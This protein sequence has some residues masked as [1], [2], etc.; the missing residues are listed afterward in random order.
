MKSNIRGL[1]RPFKNATIQT[2]LFEA[3]ANSLDAGANQVVVRLYPTAGEKETL[4][5][6]RFPKRVE[7]YD[8]ED[9]GEGFTE[10][11]RKA[12]VEAYTENKKVNGGKGIGRFAALRFFDHVD[13]ESDTGDSHISARFS[14]EFGELNEFRESPGGS[15]KKTILSFRGKSEFVSKQDVL[16]GES[17]PSAIKEHFMARLILE[18]ENGKPRT[19]VVC[20]PLSG[21]ICA[22]TPE[23][24]PHLLKYEWRHEKIETP[25]LIR[26]GVIQEN[27]A[28][29]IAYLCADNRAVEE[30]KP[31]SELPK[32]SGT[33]TL[34]VLVTGAYLDENVTDDRLSFD[35]SSP[36]LLAPVTLD[37][38]VSGVV[39]NLSAFVKEV[40]PTLD[41]DNKREEEAA[42]SAAPYLASFIKSTDFTVKHADFLVRKAKQAFEK[43]KADAKATFIRA[44]KEKSIDPEGFERACD[45]FSS[46]A[47]VAL[48]E[49][50]CYRQV[51][52][53][54]LADIA[55]SR[56]S[57]ESDLHRLFMRMQSSTR[58][59]GGGLSPLC[60][61][62][63]L[64]DRFM[65]YAYAASDTSLGRICAEIHA[66]D[67]KV[68][69]EAIRPDLFLFFSD[70]DDG[71]RGDAVVVEL[72]GPNASE[73]ERMTAQG[74]I[75][76]NL[77]SV[78]NM[79]PGLSRIWGYII[80]K[81]GPNEAQTLFSDD[82]LPLFTT[83]G[84]NKL[85]VKY[86]KNVNTYVT[87]VDPEIL[88][89]DAIA[90]NKIFIDILKTRALD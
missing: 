35:L 51:L 63:L 8:V 40:Y 54:A 60:D 58:G 45:R 76:R 3:I 12:F 66:R 6:D 52:A 26:R 28:R 33:G 41:S 16:N 71:A 86:L 38:L 55:K 17:L 53:E 32:D 46:A 24:L 9:N 42:I 65:T 73:R 57:V 11:N 50:I 47:A 30:I 29:P 87:V 4:E 85:Y 43:E 18:R 80:M 23:S 59:K 88:S 22:I 83:G 7:E 89:A 19:I 20:C 36:T 64:D 2:P 44:I 34:V 84:E 74:E 77:L 14:L 48:G 1:V 82:Y 56:D 70:S 72:K 37:D 31:L 90:R 49:Y 21:A 78:R 25:F 15:P 67:S 13:I 27:G 69:R 39:F 79:H 81:I 10:E 61:L 62:W 5:L 68:F 75:A